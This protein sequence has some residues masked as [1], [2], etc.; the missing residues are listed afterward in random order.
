M[1][2]D[3]E[4]K[5]DEL[6]YGFLDYTLGR[7][8]SIVRYNT[9]KFIKPQSLMQHLGSATLIAMLLSDYLNEVGIKNDTE[10]VMRMTIIHDID[11]VVSGDIPHEAK[12]EVEFS[13]E[14]REALSKLTDYTI[15]STLGMI[16]NKKL[17]NSYKGLFEDEKEKK[18]V[19]AKIVKLADFADVII[20]ARH[21][22]KI[23]NKSMQAIE[24]SGTRNFKE[25][26]ASV[27]SQSKGTG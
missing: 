23:G 9:A 3:V 10:R 1:E 12:Y 15:N 6:I 22:Q 17:E 27:I 24:E 14:L 20:Y 18:S 21:E 5:C 8:T 13:K 11:E 16:N 7:L 19:E 26:L 2:K 4:A 25:V